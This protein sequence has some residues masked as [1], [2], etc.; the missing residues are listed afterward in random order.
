MPMTFSILT[1]SKTTDGS[2]AHWSNYA[3]LDAPGILTEAQQ[4]L[5]SR[6]RVR[7][8]R[9]SASLSFAVGDYT[10]A[11]PT[12][13]LEPMVL[14]DIT[15]DCEIILRSEGDLEELRSWTSGM[16]DDGDPSSYSIYDELIQTDAKT[17]TAWSA[18]MLYWKQPTALAATTN[19]TNFITERYPQLLRMACLAVASR[20]RKDWETFNIEQKLCFAE[21]DNVMARDEYVRIG[22]LD[23]VQD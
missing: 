5:Y 14:R 23:P 6:L 10:K 3:L 11:L 15:N 22:Q 8:M 7:E 17:V 4:M 12:G 19:E 9:A 18:R 13:F 1:G 21:I 2:I 20:F 16:L